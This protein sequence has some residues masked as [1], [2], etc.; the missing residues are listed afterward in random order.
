MWRNTWRT[1]PAPPRL[2]AG[3]MGDKAT[4]DYKEGV[5]TITVPVPVPVPETKA[6]T[7]TIPVRHV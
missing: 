2:P 3:A 7:R 5:L 1:S 6:G 4:A